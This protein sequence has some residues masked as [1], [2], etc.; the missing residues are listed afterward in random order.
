M[1]I[2]TVHAD[3]GYPV[4]VGDDVLTQVV[5]YIPSNA[6]QVLLVA[7]RAVETIAE[8]LQTAA[9]ARGVRLTQFIPEDGEAQKTL[10]TA[11]SLWNL[12]GEKRFGRQDVII[13]LG[14]GATTDLAGFVA[15]TW[16]R[17]I[18]VL[19][20]PTSLL[21]MVD[22][23][24]GGKT[25]IN[26]PAGKNLIGAFH[27]PIAVGISI[28]AL[29]TL[30]AAEYRAGLGEVIKCGFIADRKIL[31]LIVENPLI[32]DVEWATEVG[33]DILTEL[34]SRAVEVKATV[35][36]Q[37]LKETGLREILNYGHTLAHAIE[38]YSNYTVRHGE[39]VAIGSVFAAEL[40]Q[41]L[42]YLSEND[43]DQHRRVFSS[44]GLPTSWDGPI[45]PLLDAMYSDKK[46]HGSQLRFVLLKAVEKPSSIEVSPDAILRAWT[47]RHA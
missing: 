17:G 39:A 41:D 27:S 47:G 28:S 38:K 19:Q 5:D 46:T 18:G 37:D 15:A 29:T 31:N 35:V 43:V 7:P 13:G 45:E 4:F 40:A 32:K 1:Q 24:V 33:K 2:I 11:E 26:S 8:K 36:S 25:G 9:A 3:D 14:G 44:V 22:A 21:A 10:S 42:G 12:L 34:I 6:S 23:A 30:S 20:V 16:M